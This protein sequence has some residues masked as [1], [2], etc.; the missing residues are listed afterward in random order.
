MA[1]KVV[2]NSTRASKEK[3]NPGAQRRPA[4]NRTKKQ[5]ESSGAW[6]KW[7]ILAVFSLVA[8]VAMSMSVA[9]DNR[10]RVTRPNVGS[11]SSGSERSARD[12]FDMRQ[13]C[14]ENEKD[15]EELQAR[16]A[17]IKGQ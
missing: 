17:R 8:I 6:I 13:W 9:H 15:N 5:S 10:K 12:G 3:P 14:K 4:V 11:Y 7:V 1:I 2:K 16:R